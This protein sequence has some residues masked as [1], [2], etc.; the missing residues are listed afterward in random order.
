MSRRA[1]GTT[2]QLEGPG[3]RARRLPMATATPASKLGCIGRRSRRHAASDGKPVTERCSARRRSRPRARS[4][5]RGQAHSLLGAP[6][7][8]NQGRAARGWADLRLGHIGLVTEPSLHRPI[9]LRL[10][11]ST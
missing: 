1:P 10:T 4:R 2:R 9:A 11:V 8:A 7:S 5:I 3:G 6:G